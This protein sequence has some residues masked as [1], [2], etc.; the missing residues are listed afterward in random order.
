M[1]TNFQLK[2]TTLPFL[3]WVCPITK[4]GFEFQE[5][6]VRKR[7]SILEIP[8]VLIFRQNEQLWVFGPKFAKNWILGLKFQKSKSRFRISILEILCAPIF[9]QNGHFLIFWAKFLEIDQLRA[10]FWFKYCWECCRELAGDWYE[11]S[12][13][14]WSWVE[15]SGTGW[16]WV[17][18]DG[19]GWSWVHGFVISNWKLAQMISRGCWFLF[20]H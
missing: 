3:A 5:T 6:S 9:S 16:S 18:G 4:I 1:C 20:Q 17:E 12:G 15:V 10:I 19:A 11:L 7:I 13:G 8:R 2:T 14:W